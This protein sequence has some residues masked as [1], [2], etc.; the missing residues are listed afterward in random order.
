[1]SHV[2]VLVC[3]GSACFG[4]DQPCYFKNLHTETIKYL[5]NGK[6]LYG[7]KNVYADE[8]FCKYLRKEKEFHQQTD[9]V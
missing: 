4:N 6:L 5:A 2:P 3:W 7:I 9:H 8:T 1:M